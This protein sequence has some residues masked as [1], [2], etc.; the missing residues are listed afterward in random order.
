MTTIVGGRGRWLTRSLLSA[1]SLGRVVRMEA[2]HIS[3][4]ACVPSNEQHGGNTG[5]F[6]TWTA[7]AWKICEAVAR[8]T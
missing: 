2:N 6:I 5:E 1:G 4:D 3:G 8:Y 7:D